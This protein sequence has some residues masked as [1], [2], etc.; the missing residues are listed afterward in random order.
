M[1]SNQLGIS[2]VLVPLLT[3]MYL[4]ANGFFTLLDSRAGELFIFAGSGVFCLIERAVLLVGDNGL[5][6]LDADDVLGDGCDILLNFACFNTLLISLFLLTVFLEEF[7][8]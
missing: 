1:F 7:I 6:F 2:L 8:Y 4:C 5:D 3:R